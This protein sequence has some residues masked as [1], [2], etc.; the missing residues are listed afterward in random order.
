MDDKLNTKNQDT[1]D[2]V[3]DVDQQLR[4]L[5]FEDFSGQKKIVENLDVFVKAAKMRG[6]ALDHV[7]LHGPPGLGKTTLSNILANELGVGIKITSGPVLDKP[8]DLAGL[9][10]NLDEN[11]VL[12]ID[13]IHRLSPIVEE[14]LYSAMEDFRID[15]VIDKG[16]AARSIQLELNPFTLIGATTRSGLLTSPLRARFGIN[17]HLEYYDM[18]VLTQIVKRSAKILDIEISHEAAG[19]IASRSRGTPRIVNALLRRVRDFAQV[20]GNGSIDLEIARYSLKALNID[21][22]GLDEMDNK[23]LTCIIDKFKGGPVGISTIAT[24]VSEDAGTIEEVYEPFLIKEGFIK[25]TPRGREVTALA[26]SH[27]GKSR[28]EEPN[29][30]F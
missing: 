7:L 6:E 17:S 22:H 28:F 23:I 14:Y 20:K 9:L 3:V 26:Y 5:R 13:E 30:L 11:D 25:R 15:I 2:K 1:E 19:E 8:G 24:A 27:L 10:T 16:P 4:P 12:F 18:S 21:K 29:S